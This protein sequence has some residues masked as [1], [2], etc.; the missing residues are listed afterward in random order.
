MSEFDREL[1]MDL[2]TGEKRP[3]TAA[4]PVLTSAGRIGKT[5]FRLEQQRPGALELE[6]ICCLNHL[7]I[8]HVEVPVQ[9]EWTISGETRE[10]RVEPGQFNVIPAFEP[11]AIRSPDLGEYLVV[12]LERSFFAAAAAEIGRPGSLSLRPVFG[13]DDALIRELIL[14][15]QA[16]TMGGFADGGLYAESLATALAVRLVHR[17]SVQSDLPAE[18]G[19]GLGRRRLRQVVDYIHAH[20][21][22]SVSLADLAREAGLSPFHFARQFRRTTGLPPHEYVTRCRVER[23]RELLVRPGLGIADVAVQVGFCDQ[24]H[25]A[26]HYKRIF[27]LTPAAFAR[28]VSRRKVVPGWNSVASNGLADGLR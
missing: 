21:A 8:L 12:S 6:N 23:A 26:R 14:A 7:V 17:Y 16:E 24:S 2:E 15:L 22:D 25:L 4:P 1:V 28:S 18:V 5:G 10:R 19:G 27:G 20:L 11:Y 3:A 9:L 13:D